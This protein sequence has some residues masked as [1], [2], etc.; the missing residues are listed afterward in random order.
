MT[1]PLDKSEFE[2]VLKA[3]QELGP[4]MESELVESFAEKVVAEVRR[5]QGQTAGPLSRAREQQFGV[6][7]A[8][9]Q[10]SG[11]PQGLILAIVSLVLAV[12]LS[13]IAFSM[14]GFFAGALAW[15]GIV[16][17]NF[18]AALNNRRND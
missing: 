17:V 5:Q 13:A 3:R 2:A 15:V 16:L 4:E 18:A 8:R 6:V 9:P 11:V 1:E 7:P 12:P 10:K 14:G